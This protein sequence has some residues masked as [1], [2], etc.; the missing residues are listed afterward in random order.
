MKYIIMCGGR[1]Y[2]WQI[3]RQFVMINGEAIVART[4]RLLRE[5]GVEDIAISTNDPRFG[6]YGVPLLSHENRFDTIG[7]GSWVDGF[8]PV[9][10]PVCYILGDVVFSPEAIREIVNTETDGVEF[11]ASCPPFHEDYSKPW[12]E[13]F[14]F[15]VVD[16]ERFFKARDFVRENEQTG[17]YRR[18]PISWEFWQ[19]IHGGQPNEID[20]GSYHAIND[21]TCDVDAPEDAF[22]MELIIQH[23]ERTRK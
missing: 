6:M 20:Y 7:N 11:F 4:I 1:Y 2:K 19:A 23:Y 16:L 9:T 21:Y 3:P 10:E 8:Y 5:N 17:L 14:A 18:R 15:K 13:P 12:A 22:R